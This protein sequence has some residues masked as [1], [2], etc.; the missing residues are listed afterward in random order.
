MLGSIIM[1]HALRNNNV[2]YNPHKDNLVKLVSEP[3]DFEFLLKGRD[4]GNA[5]AVFDYLQALNLNVYISGSA[6][7][8]FVDSGRKKYSDIDFVATAGNQTLNDAIQTIRKDAEIPIPIIAPA[9]VGRNLTLG[10]KSFAVSE[11]SKLGLLYM[12]S[13]SDFRFRFYSER[14]IGGLIGKVMQNIAPLADIDVTLIAQSG[15]EKY[16]LH[17]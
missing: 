2:V 7:A 13:E 5:E 9:T 8:N 10:K 3:S 16:F 15:F 4:K 11:Y 6:L 14:S 1:K 12:H 17:K